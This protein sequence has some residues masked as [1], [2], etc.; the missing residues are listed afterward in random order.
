MLRERLW[1]DM[2]E[3]SGYNAGDFTVAWSLPMGK[4]LVGNRSS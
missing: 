2:V 4:F 3:H 1:E